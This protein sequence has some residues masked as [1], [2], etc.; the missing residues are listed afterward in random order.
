MKKR[1]FSLLVT[2]VVSLTATTVY[3]GRQAIFE[4]VVTEDG[5]TQK[6]YEILTVDDNRFRIDFVGEDKKVTDQ[7]P[8]IMTIDDGDTWVM[9]D[10]PKDKFYCS[11]MATKEFFKNIGGQ[12]TQ[13]VEFFNVK[14]AEPT[15]QE[16]LREP[17]P[18]MLGMKTTHVRLETDAKA[19]V[20]VI[21]KFEYTVKMVEDI[22]YTTDVGLHS[23]RKKWM[24][25]LTQSGNKLIDDLFVKFA[26][27]LPGPIL[28]FESTTDITNVR[29]KKT[30]TQ[31]VRTEMISL[32]DKEKAE[33]DKIFVMPK[34]VMMDDD[35]IQE[36]GKTL[37]SRQKLML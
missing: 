15:V 9:G 7:T 30:S 12:L 22:W 21:L 28:K 33:L 35:E 13:A 16:T 3:A 26:A 6:S 5:T 37:L 19:H 24:T 10:K 1:L 8:Y 36:K 29:K 27:K 20:R 25:A 17:G 23:V 31:K 11:E 2:L 18:E 14:V 4:V 32:D 34:C